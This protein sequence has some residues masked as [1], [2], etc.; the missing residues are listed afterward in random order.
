MS[1]DTLRVRFINALTATIELFDVIDS[2]NKKRIA[3]LED[4]VKQLQGEI[5][6][7]QFEVRHLQKNSKEA[8]QEGA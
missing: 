6:E 3:H 5:H 2:E 1:E 7:L 8:A 4:T